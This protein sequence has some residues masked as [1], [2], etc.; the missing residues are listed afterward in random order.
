VLDHCDPWPVIPLSTVIGVPI[1]GVLQL[2]GRLE[3]ERRHRQSESFTV[4]RSLANPPVIGL[5]LVYSA[6]S[7]PITA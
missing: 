4:A 5:S 1:S 3:I 2:T 6:R 7:R